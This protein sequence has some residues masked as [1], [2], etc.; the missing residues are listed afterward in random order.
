VLKRG[1]ALA[2]AHG[3]LYR[4]AALH[5]VRHAR[6]YT[7]ARALFN[8]GLDAAPYYAPLY[9]AAAEVEARIGNIG[10]LA[11]LDRRAKAN[12]GERQR[13]A[14][15]S[16]A[17]GGGGDAY[18]AAPEQ[19]GAQRAALQVRNGGPRQGLIG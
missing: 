9:H 19:L 4:A 14:G 7:A 13:D 16:G 18:G 15:A 6:D 2:P 10:A 12:F 1:L 5:A 11:E 17:D 8:Q 3:P